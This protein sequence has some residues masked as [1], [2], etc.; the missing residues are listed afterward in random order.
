MSKATPNNQGRSIDGGCSF[1]NC[2]KPATDLIRQPI[3]TMH[4]LKVYRAAQALILDATPEQ[5]VEAAGLDGLGVIYF[6]QKADRI[7]IGHT[8]DL[9]RRLREIPHDR[10]LAAIPGSLSDEKRAHITFQESRDVG[11][12]FHATPTLLQ[13]IAALRF[14]RSAA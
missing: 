4:C 14:S 1:P 7:K 6:V 5:V 13:G 9:D 10:V 2:D 3:C 8:T 12:W 11:E